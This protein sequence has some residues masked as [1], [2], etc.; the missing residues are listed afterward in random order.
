MTE[1]KW[2]KYPEEKPLND[3][4]CY[5]TNKKSGFFCYVCMYSA[6]YD[7]FR[8]YDPSIH[9]QPPVEVTHWVELPV[10]PGDA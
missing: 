5:V 3:I 4:V 7:Y 9:N 2:K 1:M 6:H 10:S 8:L